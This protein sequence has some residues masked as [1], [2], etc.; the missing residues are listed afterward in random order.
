MLVSRSHQEPVVNRPQPDAIRVNSSASP[1]QGKA[2]LLV[3]IV[4]VLCICPFSL[5]RVPLGD[6]N[7]AIPVLPT[8]AMPQ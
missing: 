5:I 4:H 1:F 2:A 7:E 8:L 6:P 3:P